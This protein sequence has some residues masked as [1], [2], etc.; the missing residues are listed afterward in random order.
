MASQ[1][2]QV[3]RM[4]RRRKRHRGALHVER[5]REL[6][7]LKQP[8]EARLPLCVH[9]HYLAVEH[10]VAFRKLREGARDVREG[11][12]RVT[13]AAQDE[14]GLAL[15]PL[16]EHPEAIVLELEQPAGRG[17]RLLAVLRQHQ[18]DVGRAQGH[19]R[20]DEGM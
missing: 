12:G 2:E 17:E 13:A 14:H 8:L 15:L 4:H 10:H 16:G 9:T 3:E 11:L 19:E 5:T 1:G 6:R 20:T 7:A 18:L